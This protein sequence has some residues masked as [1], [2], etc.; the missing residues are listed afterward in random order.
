MKRVDTLTFI[1]FFGQVASSSVGSVIILY[2][3][4]TV[5]PIFSHSNV[6]STCSLN[7]FITVAL[8]TGLWTTLWSNVSN[9]HGVHA[10]KLR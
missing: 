6:I 3:I 4:L 2:V 10:R 7:Y 8:F 9:I 5:N 1:M